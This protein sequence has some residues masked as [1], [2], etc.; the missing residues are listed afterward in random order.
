MCVYEYLSQFQIRITMPKHH[1]SCILCSNNTFKNPTVVIFNTNICEQ[2]YEDTCK[3]THAGSLRWYI[4][5]NILQLHYGFPR[6]LPGS[7]PTINTLLHTTELDHG[8]QDQLVGLLI[9]FL[10]SNVTFFVLNIYFFVF[11]VLI[12]FIHSGSWAKPEI[13]S[14]SIFCRA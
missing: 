14:R 8:Y 7:V 5:H 10:S 12:S 6:L 2:H 11:R 3:R 13:C 4:D 1:R 9:F